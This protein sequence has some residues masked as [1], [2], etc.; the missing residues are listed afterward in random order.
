MDHD[1]HCFSANCRMAGPALTLRIHTADILMIGKALSI[2]PRGHVLIIDGQGELNTALWGGATTASARLKGLA[3]VVID[4]AIRDVAA[5]RRDRLPV[6][7]R[8]VVPNAGGAE[9]AGEM[10]VPIQCGGVVVNPGDWVI[11]DEDGVVVIP[12]DR[13]ASVVEKA[14]RLVEVEKMIDREIRLGKDLASILHYDEVLERKS[15]EA[16]LPQMRFLQK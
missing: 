7:A 15:K 12:A 14:V 5:I 9:Y 10:H 8:A 1:V 11:G 2:C 4:G 3:G 16:F 13:L 6:F